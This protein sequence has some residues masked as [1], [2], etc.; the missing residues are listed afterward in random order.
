MR[1]LGDDFLQAC[2][3]MDVPLEALHRLVTPK[4][5]DTWDA[6]GRLIINDWRAEQPQQGVGGHPFRGTSITDRNIIVVP[7]LAAVDLTALAKSELNLTYLDPDYEQWN[8]YRGNDGKEIS[9]RGK[10]FE[11]LIWK[12]ELASG[13]YI[14]SEPVRKHFR[15]LGFYG[16]AGAF[17][18]WR[19]TCGLEGYHVSIPEDNGCW[20]DSDGRLYAPYSYFDDGRRELG[21]DWVGRK[22]NGYW[23]FV[24]FR[25]LSV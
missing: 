13:A 8:Y 17:T 6:I 4:G 12:P 14:N 1:G 24:A 2:E 22:W 16:H 15:D 11:V 25:E 9:G 18:Q 23:S 19:R 3:R 5:R 10:R 7:D 21:H 20:R